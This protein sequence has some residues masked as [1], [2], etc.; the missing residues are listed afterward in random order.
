MEVNRSPFLSS[1]AM[2]EQLPKNNK[3]QIIST[4]TLE[5]VCIYSLFSTCWLTEKADF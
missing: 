2:A 4:N 3:Q 1:F 5:Q